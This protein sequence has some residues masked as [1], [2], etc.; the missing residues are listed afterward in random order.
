MAERATMG[1]LDPKRH[2]FWDWVKTG[3]TNYQPIATST[4]GLTN[5]CLKTIYICRN[6]Y[7]YIYVCRNDRVDTRIT[8]EEQVVLKCERFSPRA[9]NLK[10]NEMNNSFRRLPKILVNQVELSSFV[11]KLI[12]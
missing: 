8:I 1:A 5:K 6:M 2:P 10:A 9:T 7:I 11:A 4:N 3:K 12:N